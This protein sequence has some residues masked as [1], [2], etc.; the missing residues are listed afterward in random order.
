MPE[1]IINASGPQYG[2]VINPDGSINVSGIDLAIGSLTFNA[3]NVY[4]TSGDNMNLGSAWTGAGSVYLTNQNT[5]ETYAGS[6][7]WVKNTIEVSGTIDVNNLYAGSQVY[8]GDIFGVS[9][10]VDINNKVAGSIVDWPGTI[11]V[12]NFN[13]LGSNSVITNFG[14]LGSSRVITNLGD[15]GSESWIRGG[16]IEVTTG[17]IYVT[18][19][20]QGT[21][22]AGSDAYIPAGSVIV[23][24]TIAGSIISIPEV[25]ITGSIVNNQVTPI[26]TS[27]NNPAYKFEYE[28]DNIGSITQFIGAGS[29]VQV[30]TWA[31][32]SVLTNIGSYT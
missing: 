26:D 29:Y 4:V 8:Q 16:S 12:S 6:E 21:G 23:T 9:G 14:D 30:L 22:Y 18:N 15:I 1:M 7:V 5:I 11:E 32:G 10:I 24:N 25:S 2:L 27:Q 31:N 13:A 20:E 19:F 17:S 28:G 3:G